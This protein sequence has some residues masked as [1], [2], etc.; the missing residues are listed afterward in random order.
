MSI[1]DFCSSP[2]VAWAFPCRNLTKPLEVPGASVD[3]NSFGSWAA[4]RTCHDLIVAGKRDELTQRS[5]DT[6]PVNSISP[7]VLSVELRKLHDTFWASRN[8]SPVP[9]TPGAPD[10]C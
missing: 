9:T 4:C 10:P 2:D 3:F 6:F 8:G 1:C 5:V 7:E